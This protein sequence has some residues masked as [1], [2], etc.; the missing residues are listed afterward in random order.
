MERR[1]RAMWQNV[2]NDY[3]AHL[4]AAGRSPGTVRL[5]RMHLERLFSYFGRQ[6]ETLTL[7]DLTAYMAAHNWKPE[8][9]KSVRASVRGFYEWAHVT[10]RIEVDPSAKLPKVSTPGGQPAPASDAA[11]A[12]AMSAAD[13]ETRLMVCLA[14]YAG[15]RR[16]EVASLHSDDILDSQLRITGKGGKVRL[17]PLHPLLREALTGRPYGFVFPGKDHGHMSADWVGRRIS[18]VLPDKVTAHKLRHRF[19]TRAYAAERD[20]LS[21]QQLLGHT[22]VATTQRYT[23]VPDDAKMRAVL[24]VA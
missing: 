2:L 5:R 10:D 13:P 3:T 18:A 17:V 11:V 19:A 21:V 8:T 7:D 22:S 15:L 6:P 24:N 1:N 9:R 16:A 12:Q 4:M 20:I 23:E 14:L